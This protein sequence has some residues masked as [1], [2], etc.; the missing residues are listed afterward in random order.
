VIVA[1]TYTGRDLGLT[2]Q[3]ARYYQDSRRQVAWA[4]AMAKEYPSSR[5]FYQGYV[6]RNDRDARHWMAKLMQLAAGKLPGTA[7]RSA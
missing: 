3:L 1:I 7:R 2:L 6:R 5:R 4:R